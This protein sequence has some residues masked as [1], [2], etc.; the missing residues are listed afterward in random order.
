[1][2]KNKPNLDIAM[3]I[4]EH[5]EELRRRMI[6]ALIGLAVGACAMLAAGRWLI[7]TLCI[8]LND[9]LLSVGLPPRLYTHNPPSGFTI[10]L[11]ISLIAGFVLASPWIVYQVWLFIVSGLHKSE[12][13]V[14]LTLVPFSTAMTALGVMFMYFI[15]LPVCLWFFINFTVG[16]PAMGD[17]DPGFMATL[18]NHQRAEVTVPGG[19]PAADT[20]S[21]TIA[22]HSDDPP[23][24]G[25]GA[26]WLKVPELELRVAHDGRVQ[27]FV[28]ATRNQV[29]LLPELGQYLGFVGMLTIGIVVAF[30]LPVLMLVLGW[31]GVL[32]AETIAQSRRYCIFGCFVAGALLTPA[33]VLSMLLLAIPLWG[34]FEFGLLLMRVTQA[35]E[36]KGDEERAGNT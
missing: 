27:S 36:P 21:P 5:I 28:P 29:S 8:P 35:R 23:T 31:T 19:P 18:M 33:D 12:R 9:A 16:Y 4:G 7:V 14:V 10:Y 30:Q 17:H 15:M 11:K 6:M 26:I 25:N 32:R 1:M 24:P 20:S 13:R 3:S 2:G 22:V 34:L